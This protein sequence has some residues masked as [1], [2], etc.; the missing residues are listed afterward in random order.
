MSKKI[1]SLIPD[2]IKSPI[3]R[4]LYDKVFQKYFDPKDQNISTINMD[5]DREKYEITPSVNID[6]NISY[7]QPIITIDNKEYSFYDIISLLQYQNFNIG[8][9]NTFH[10][11]GMDVWASCKTNS[12]KLPINIDK[13][14]N[15]TDYC[16]VGNTKP[17]YVVIRNDF[18]QQ[19]EIE[20]N[21]ARV[22]NNNALVAILQSEITNNI[23]TLDPNGGFDNAS[24]GFDEY[25]FDSQ[26]VSTST[27]SGTNWEFNNRWIHKDDLEIGA[28]Y[29][30][31]KMPIIEY[32]NKIELVK[33][34]KINHAWKYRI[35]S[36]AEWQEVD[37]APSSQEILSGQRELVDI[38]TYNYINNNDKRIYFLANSIPFLNGSQFVIDGSDIRWTVNGAI[39][40]DVSGLKYIE[41]L[42]DNFRYF[43]FSDSK[44]LVILDNYDVINVDSTGA[45]TTITVKGNLSSF[46][47]LSGS[48]TILNFFNEFAQ[49]YNYDSYIINSGNTVITLNNAS[50][51]PTNDLN[52]RFTPTT[53]T[54]QGDEWIGFFNQWCYDGIKHS[55][56][57][58]DVVEIQPIGIDINKNT[59]NE[60]VQVIELGTS[61]PNSDLLVK[62]TINNIS[63]YDFE[64]GNYDGITFEPLTSIYGLINAI[65]LKNAITITVP[66]NIK[67]TVGAC[68]ATDIPKENLQVRTDIETKTISNV[69][70]LEYQTFN[71]K[72]TKFNIYPLF[73]QYTLSATP[74]LMD[75]GVHII[76]H[77]QD[78]NGL[79]IPEIN[80][81]VANNNSDLLFDIDICQDSKH[82]MYKI[83]NEYK[84]LW[85]NQTTTV[86]PI[87]QVDSNGYAP[88]SIHY[89]SNTTQFPSIPDYLYGNINNNTFSVV[90]RNDLS[91]HF[92]TI[93]QLNNAPIR[94]LSDV[95]YHDNTISNL[96]IFD[97]IFPYVVN[98]ITNNKKIDV[99]FEAHKQ[100]RLSYLSIF[101]N[102]LFQTFN[103]TNFLN[104]NDWYENIKNQILIYDSLK[105]YDNQLNHP[106]TPAMLTKSFATQP[107][108]SS[109]Y[110][111]SHDGILIEYDMLKSLYINKMTLTSTYAT[112]PP[113]SPSINQV[114]Y[115]NDHFYIYNGVVWQQET[116]HS[117]V[118]DILSMLETELYNMC[119]TIDSPILNAQINNAH[120]ERTQTQL[121]LKYAD[122]IQNKYPFSNR[123][124]Y[125]LSNAFTW[126]YLEIIDI[127]NVTSPI[128]GLPTLTI[129]HWGASYK[130]IYNN[131]F[132]T[133]YPNIEPWKIQGYKLKPSWWDT[134]YKDNTN[135]RLWNSLMWSNI[136]S[137]IVPSSELLPDHITVSTGSI[138][139]C[140]MYNFVPVNTTASVIGGVMSDGLLPPFRSAVDSL[141]NNVL[142]NN[143]NLIDLSKSN[144]AEDVFGYGTL[145]EWRWKQQIT[146]NYDVL[147]GMV[148]SDPRN[149]FKF[150]NVI[151]IDNVKFNN[152]LLITPSNIRDTDVNFI[153]ELY[154]KYGNFYNKLLSPEEFTDLNTSMAI[155][156]GTYVNRDVVAIDQI[157]RDLVDVLRKQNQFNVIKPVT[158]FKISIQNI[159]ASKRSDL[160]HN[161][162]FSI[163][164]VTSSVNVVE[165]FPSIYSKLAFTTSNS[166]TI[167][168]DVYNQLITGTKITVTWD[169]YTPEEFIEQTDFYVIKRGSNTISL[170]RSI[171][172]LDTT[173]YINLPINYPYDVYIGVITKQFGVLNRQIISKDFN[174]YA[175]N[176]N[177]SRTVTLPVIVNGIQELINFL[178]GYVLK[179]NNEGIF[180]THFTLQ[181][182]NEV[183]NRVE[184][185]QLALEILLATIYDDKT[186]RTLFF[187]NDYYCNIFKNTLFI[188]TEKQ[189]LS[190]AHDEQLRDLSLLYDM[191][192]NNIPTSQIVAFRT[193]P[194]I[195]ESAVNIGGALLSLTTSQDIIKLD[196]T[197]FTMHNKAYPSSIS[198]TSGVLSTTAGFVDIDGTYEYNFEE[199]TTNFKNINTTS[200]TNPQLK[201]LSQQQLGYQPISNN[202]LYGLSDDGGFKLWRESLHQKGSY[203]NLVPFQTGFNQS[204]DTYQLINSYQYSFGEDFIFNITNIDL[205]NKTYMKQNS[206]FDFNN[207]PIDMNFDNNF[208]LLDSTTISSS[209]A[210]SNIDFNVSN[211]NEYCLDIHFAVDE[212]IVKFSI[213]RFT[214]T[215]MTYSITQ[216]TDITGVE[217]FING[218]KTSFTYVKLSNSFDISCII[219]DQQTTDVVII[220]PTYIRKNH[221]TFIE[222]YKISFDLV[223]VL[224]TSNTNCDLLAASISTPSVLMTETNLSSLKK[225]EYVDLANGVVPYVD[226]VSN[227]DPFLQLYNVVDNVEISNTSNRCTQM[228]N[229]LW[230]KKSNWYKPY[231]NVFFG[232]KYCVSNYNQSF[233]DDDGVYQFIDTDIH[234]STWMDIIDSQE[235]NTINGVPVHSIQ[236][237]TRVNNT[238]PWS[239]WTTAQIQHQ[240]LTTTSLTNTITLS[241]GN[242]GD[243]INVFVNGQFH[244][245]VFHETLLQVNISNSLPTNVIDLFI[246]PSIKENDEL[247]EYRRGFN[248]YTYIQSGNVRYTYWIKEYRDSTSKNAYIVNTEL[249][250]KLT[251]MFG[252]INNKIVIF[253]KDTRWKYPQLLVHN[254]KITH[255]IWSQHTTSSNTSKMSR[256]VWEQVIK[257]ANSAYRDLQLSS[258]DTVWITWAE[259]VSSID[260]ILI[261]NVDLISPYNINE[262]LLTINTTYEN[263][264]KLYDM[265]TSQ[266]INIII[267]EITKRLTF[268]VSEYIMFS[269]LCE[270]S[271]TEII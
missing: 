8:L 228:I 125:D 107:F 117:V 212:P 60:I 258:K 97:T 220:L 100:M 46:I 78:K 270:I 122:S 45:N 91:K 196:N 74:Q 3:N 94:V 132:N 121:Y 211:H 152:G 72:Q 35:S 170:C 215:T 52:G 151:E 246:I 37:F 190:L 41:V 58:N 226:Y 179:L 21:N 208:M 53:F 248:Y 261:N 143:V 178:H 236:I 23:N 156:P 173:N 160:L 89:T 24:Y 85:S 69:S 43:R 73:K 131:L 237:R 171:K 27:L 114:Y 206:I 241:I 16:W 44:Q 216:N 75:K 256:R 129:N 79:Y 159:D 110:L 42:E 98:I 202:S 116:I 51:R 68:T 146:H 253:N 240:Q 62:L 96:N 266:L 201:S 47:S 70:L 32:S 80:T 167:N 93:A 134:Y 10:N 239:T 242:V 198:L 180:E 259:L 194:I 115:D 257:S 199:L 137:G 66:L 147:L 142:I 65:K 31:A 210:V 193:N 155:I 88:S 12:L 13:F 138:G 260:N 245:L 127:T 168:T 57:T 148:K 128:V 63:V 86:V 5:L 1:I 28:Q 54:S 19:K 174:I 203:E 126:N 222:P 269:S 205:N 243:V 234:P 36:V 204:V 157:N 227:T 61:V 25:N 112:T 50:P 191:Q 140:Q 186:N 254:N 7:Y 177:E 221:Y 200:K 265:L 238:S 182:T 103:G 214:T 244:A 145:S 231:N 56:V 71:Q 130:E 233:I 34:I 268:D 213:P 136:L 271:S 162:S 133:P 139:S 252:I 64:Y 169:G 120:F 176:F 33:W 149:L 38:F 153:Y 39:Q 235:T 99:V 105:I 150:R 6:S 165:I 181:N 17:N 154:K 161:C 184:N 251:N 22:A 124:E 197:V 26:I 40:T 188:N 2:T 189:L 15:Y 166:A 29:Q 113:L 172:E 219:N 20:I 175:S 263:V 135:T 217:L 223:D 92:D 76:K 4:V 18:I 106:L 101:L 87:L 14:V 183:Y 118:L 90:S 225:F 262:I 30:I 82:T 158:N 249:K 59:L 267:A 185:F 81:T 123:T 195:V 232:E 67:I 9:D 104:K 144:N 102:E 108:V 119:I 218:S 247:I 187:G 111:M 109:N 255:D 48:F 77:K 230:Y 55:K 84:H 207:I 264:D 192:N 95:N 224:I 83:N 209:S 141:Y 250:N 163:N 164:S 11:N 229:K 49:I